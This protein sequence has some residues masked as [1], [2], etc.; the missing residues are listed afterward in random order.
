ME[1][2]LD[3]SHKVCSFCGKRGGFSVKLW[4]LCKVDL[5]SHVFFLN[6]FSCLDTSCENLGLADGR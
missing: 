3:P 5:G 1:D 6:V 4:D 2:I